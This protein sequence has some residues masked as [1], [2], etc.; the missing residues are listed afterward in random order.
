[1]SASPLS[2]SSIRLYAGLSAMWSAGLRVLAG[3]FGLGHYFRDK[4]VLALLQAF[5]DNIQVERPR[6]RTFALQQLLDGLF[7]VFHERLAKQRHFLQEFLYA[8]LDHFFDDVRRLAGLSSLSG[9]DIAFAL[10]DVR[11]N[12]IL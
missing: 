1:M 12:L 7:V 8:A 4:I 9:S 3:L 2:L 11:R 10:D 5:A 6:A